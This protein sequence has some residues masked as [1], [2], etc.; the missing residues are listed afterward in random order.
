MNKNIF[1]R[2]FIFKNKLVIKMLSNETSKYIPP[3][4][5]ILTDNDKLYDEIKT[6]LIQNLFGRNSY[7]IYRLC[8]KD[9]LSRNFWMKNSRLLITLDDFNDELDFNVLI[10]Y[11]R[12]GGRILSIPSNNKNYLKNTDEIGGIQIYDKSFNFEN[13]YINKSF[14]VENLD[15]FFNKDLFYCY[16][17]KDNTIN[18]GIHFVTKVCI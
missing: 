14:Y 11:L 6:N 15:F 4:I 17:H 8:L 5:L 13:H 12:I 3:N 9:F 16:K 10:D 18:K 2:K 1:T 7:T